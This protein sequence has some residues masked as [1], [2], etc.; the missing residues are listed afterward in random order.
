MQK[1]MHPAHKVIW[2]N[3][4]KKISKK[5]SH[6]HLPEN[7]SIDIKYWLWYKG[8]HYGGTYYEKRNAVCINTIK[9]TEQISICK[10]P[11]T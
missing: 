5:S 9:K 3:I 7:L 2:Y 8:P 11:Y 1:K 6:V 10:I 4:L